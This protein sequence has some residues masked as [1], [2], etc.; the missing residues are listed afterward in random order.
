MAKKNYISMGI[1][2]PIFRFTSVRLLDSA[3]AAKIHYDY[4][5]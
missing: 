3:G 1:Y 2:K 5:K 4:I